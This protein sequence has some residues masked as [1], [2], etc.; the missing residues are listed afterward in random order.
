MG[1]FSNEISHVLLLIS[2]HYA[3]KNT[4]SFIPTNEFIYHIFRQ[5]H[6]YNTHIG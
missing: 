4:D 6:V 5:Q 2:F 3:M 1:Y